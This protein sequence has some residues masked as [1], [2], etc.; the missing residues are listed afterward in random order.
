MICTGSTCATMRYLACH[1]MSSSRLCLLPPSVKWV[2]RRQWNKIEHVTWLNLEHFTT[3]KRR[4]KQ[5]YE[6]VACSG[7]RQLALAQTHR[8][9]KPRGKA[10]QKRREGSCS[11][12]FQVKHI[13]ANWEQLIEAVSWRNWLRFDV[14]D[15]SIGK[16]WRH[17]RRGMDD[18]R[19]QENL[20]RMAWVII[21][22]RLRCRSFERLKDVKGKVILSWS[23][24]L[25]QL[26]VW[27]GGGWDP[28]CELL[29]R[30]RPRSG[31]VLN[32]SRIIE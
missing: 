31:Q 10:R 14:C 28:T 8:R 6:N 1:F 19:W 15:R 21:V 26:I 16:W 25:D 29:C 7:D 24:M 32:W 11:L 13:E 5:M 30:P 20:R 9:R 23:I 12:T 17:C 4:Y 27:V 3:A 22:K 18:K 2:F